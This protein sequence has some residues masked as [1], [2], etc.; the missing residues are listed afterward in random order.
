MAA[1]SL[2]QVSV[3][4][5]GR[6]DIRLGHDFNER[7]TA[8]IAVDERSELCVMH[9][10]SGVLLNVNP[11]DADALRA[12]RSFDIHVSVFAERQV[13]LGYLI[14]LGKIGIKVVFAVLFG[15]TRN[16]AVGG[17]ACLDGII[18]NLFVQ[19][20]K[21]AGIPMQTGHTCV[22]GSAPKSV[23]QLQ[24]IF[25]FVFNS[26]WTSNPMTIS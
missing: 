18:H 1:R 26:T 25:V 3:R 4:F 7:H 16:C 5:F 8:A 2:R 14:G 13:V 9:K 22:F 11:G 12:V 23:L 17:K 19:H 15:K 10:L 24:K 20:W 21:R 6:A